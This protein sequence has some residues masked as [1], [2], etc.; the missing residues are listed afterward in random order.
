MVHFLT[1]PL[2]HPLPHPLITTP[3][4]GA[5]GIEGEKSRLVLFAHHSH[6]GHAPQSRRLL[7]RR[8]PRKSDK[9]GANEWHEQSPDSHL[10]V[11]TFP[12]RR[13]PGDPLSPVLAMN[14]TFPTNPLSPFVHSHH[15]PL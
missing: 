5:C 4:T 10:R 11:E 2:T 3:V 9:N 13:L 7:P 1:Y 8:G 15:N 14:I 6:R 12:P